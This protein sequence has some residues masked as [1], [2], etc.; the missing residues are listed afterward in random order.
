MF[1]L[2]AYFRN[3]QV[4]VIICILYFLYK[5]FNQGLKVKVIRVDINIG[6]D[7]SNHNFKYISNIIKIN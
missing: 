2:N 7:K 4:L 5:Y 6:V 3:L 1:T